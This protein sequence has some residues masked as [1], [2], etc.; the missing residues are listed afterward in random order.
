MVSSGEDRHILIAVDDSENAKHAVLYAADFLGGTPGFRVTLFTVIPEPPK[1]H[2]GAEAERA[3]WV[4]GQRSAAQGMLD[5]YRRVLVQSGFE[6]DKVAAVVDVRHCQ[7]VADCVL[8]MQRKLE[9]CTV[10]IGRRGISR[11]EEFLFG[12]TSS[13]IV[14][15][16]K[17]CAVWVIE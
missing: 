4:E 13:R 6:E 8:Q 11:K 3:S 17:N 15:S 2:F 9:C 14:H 16:E 12:S 10:V 7:S 1:D 5:G